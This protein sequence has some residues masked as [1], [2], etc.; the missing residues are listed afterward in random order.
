MLRKG[1]KK[2]YRKFRKAIEENRKLLYQ[3][4]FKYATVRRWMR[5]E[6]YPRYETAL[7]LSGILNLPIVEVPYYQSFRSS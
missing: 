7:I 1:M 4:G 6:R 3:K 2:K 5:G